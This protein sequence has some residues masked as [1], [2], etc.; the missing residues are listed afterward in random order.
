MN[1]L[2]TGGAGFLGQRLAHALLNLPNL[3]RLT[4]ADVVLPTNP[5]DN[6]AHYSE[7]QVECVQADLTDPQAVKAL[8][9]P[10]LN[11]I[12]HLAAVVSGQAEADFVY[13][14]KLFGSVWGRSASGDY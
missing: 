8:V 6:E 10:G 12:Y 13:F 1:I 4:L 11:A 14:C 2:I 5:K 3:Q 7:A 9:K